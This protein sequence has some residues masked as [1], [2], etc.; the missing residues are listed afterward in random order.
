MAAKDGK[1][2]FFLS[3]DLLLAFEAFKHY[4]DYLE[5]QKRHLPHL[6]TQETIEDLETKIKIAGFQQKRFYDL[7]IKERRGY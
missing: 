3:S 4:A 5:G 2:V 1:S 6:A 7:Y